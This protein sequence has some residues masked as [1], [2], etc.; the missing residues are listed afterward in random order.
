MKVPTSPVIVPLVQVTAAL[1]S[2][3]KFDAA[4]DERS[5]ERDDTRGGAL[6]RDAESLL[7]AAESSA[8]ATRAPAASLDGASTRVKWIGRLCTYMWASLGP[9]CFSIDGFPKR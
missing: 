1:A 8:N 4:A 6:R 3:A 5:L 9:G 7:Q 2:T